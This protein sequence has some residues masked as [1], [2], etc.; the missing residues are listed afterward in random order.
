MTDHSNSS[1]W[2]QTQT[3]HKIA[4]SHWVKMDCICMVLA[5]RLST[6]GRRHNY[7]IKHIPRVQY[8]GL[9][10]PNWSNL[11]EALETS[12]SWKMNK[13]GHKNWMHTRVNFELDFLRKRKK[14]KTQTLRGS[15][16]NNLV[17]FFWFGS[18]IPV[19]AEFYSTARYWNSFWCERSNS[20]N[21]KQT[22]WSWK[23]C[24]R[25]GQNLYSRDVRIVGWGGWREAFV[26]QSTVSM[27]S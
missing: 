12:F 19:E 25:C 10:N 4:A 9:V 17:T 2:L 14:K 11:D 23:V 20:I 6:N 13:Q 22:R 3:L 1:A 5:G 16:S 26:K 7:K 18:I 8:F 15:T 21:H 24:G 27:I